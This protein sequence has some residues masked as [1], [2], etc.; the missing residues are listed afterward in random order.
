MQ[1]NLVNDL[2]VQ[3][4]QHLLKLSYDKGD[5]IRQDRRS[6]EVWLVSSST[7]P[8]VWYRVR[9]GQ[10][11]GCEWFV[12]RRTACRHMC[13]VSYELYMTRKAAKVAA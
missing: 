12:H 7:H 4:R 10:S 9:D 5:R 1:H 3:R 13:R 6:S 2:S 8:N 11:C